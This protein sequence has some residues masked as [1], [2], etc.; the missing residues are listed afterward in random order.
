M[1]TDI[2]LLSDYIPRIGTLE[3]N[4]ELLLITPHSM[5]IE[6]VTEANQAL[7]TADAVRG[8]PRN[9]DATVPWSAAYNRGPESP[10]FRDAAQGDVSVRGRY[11]KQWLNSLYHQHPQYAGSVPTVQGA[12]GSERWGP[13]QA[14]WMY[15]QQQQFGRPHVKEEQVSSDCHQPGKECMW[16]SLWLCISLSFC[17]LLLNVQE[18]W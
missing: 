8:T 2:R 11:I 17:Q 9:G 5:L 16:Y 4:S 15:Q 13:A 3:I 10:Q 7:Y 18:K 14:L 1:I 12:Q 6:C